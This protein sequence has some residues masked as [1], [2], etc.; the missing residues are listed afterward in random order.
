LLKK[1][2]KNKILGK[3]IFLEKVKV[4]DYHFI[5]YLRRNSK[6]NKFIHKI[7][8]QKKKQ[9]LYLKSLKKNQIYFLIKII[10]NNKRIGTI[11]ITDINYKKK[12][13]IIGSWILKK[14]YLV[15][16]ESFFLA[17]KYS[18]SNLKLNKVYCKVENKNVKAIAFQKSIRS[19]KI[20]CKKNTIILNKKKYKVTKFEINK[21]TFA[22]IKNEKG[23]LLLKKLL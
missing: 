16:F 23:F 6:I 10:K 12:K 13:A 3:N 15:A 14:N 9:L 8:R 18:F 1:N 22:N 4:K 19:K 11:S 17:L 7:P 21:K 20:Y 2:Y 5:Y